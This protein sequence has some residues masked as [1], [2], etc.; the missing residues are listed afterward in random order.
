MRASAHATSPRCTEPA[1]AA[2]APNNPPTRTCGRRDAPACRRP[3]RT[4]PPAAVRGCSRLFA[5]V[6]AVL[7]VLPVMPVMPAVD[8]MNGLRGMC[9]MR[10]TRTRRPVR[11][12][13]AMHAMPALPLKLRHTQPLVKETTPSALYSQRYTM[14]HREVGILLLCPE[15][16]QSSV[17]IPELRI[18]EFCP[19]KNGCKRS[20]KNYE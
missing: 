12:T 14:P 1:Q 17:G 3:K 10:G 5:A 13:H 7:A 8:A 2:R 9:G 6:L 18:P 15:R 19:V 16:G 4:K 11:G 20:L